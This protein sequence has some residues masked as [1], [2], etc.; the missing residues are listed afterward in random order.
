MA[1][2]TKQFQSLYNID[3]NSI[4]MDYD[5]LIDKYQNYLAL[6]INKQEY[7]NI[8][9]LETVI[10]GFAYYQSRFFGDEDIIT[11]L[12]LVQYVNESVN[13]INIASS[14]ENYQPTTSELIFQLS[15]ACDQ[16]LYS[17]GIVTSNAI[18]TP[19]FLNSYN[20]AKTLGKYTTK[21]RGM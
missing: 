10:E 18:T 17:T 12:D 4:V 13:A 1:S 11:P 20:I 3:Q 8:Q 16:I 15:Y 21:Y 14:V 7:R 2:F 5:Y 9:F 19:L 6:F